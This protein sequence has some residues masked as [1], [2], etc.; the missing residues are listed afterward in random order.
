MFVYIYKYEY[1]IM[2]ICHMYCV[3]K[4]NPCFF[5]YFCNPGTNNLSCNPG[6]TVSD[7]A[8]R[9]AKGPPIIGPPYGKRDPYYSHYVSTK[10]NFANYDSSQNGKQKQK[11]VDFMKKYDLSSKGAAMLVSLELCNDGVDCEGDG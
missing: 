11:Y 8:H 4:T 5:G 6:P 2:Y 1:Q 3:S 10:G 7:S 9:P